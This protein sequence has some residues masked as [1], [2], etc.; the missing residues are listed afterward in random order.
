VLKNSTHC[1]ITQQHLDKYG[2]VF[3]TGPMQRKN[4]NINISANY[5]QFSNYKALGKKVAHILYL[6]Q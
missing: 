5:E 1:L 2:N 3:V 6:L 4:K